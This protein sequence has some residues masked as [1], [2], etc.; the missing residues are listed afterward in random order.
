MIRKIKNK[1]IAVAT[2]AGCNKRTYDFLL[3]SYDFN[4]VQK[5]KKKNEKRHE[6]NLSD[7]LIKF[8]IMK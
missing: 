4:F 5:R 1:K 6:K 7:N 2:A 3:C 8:L